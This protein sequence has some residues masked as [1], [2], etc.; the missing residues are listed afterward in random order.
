M[1]RKAATQKSSA[2]KRRKVA[3]SFKPSPK[4]S[5]YPE[6]H[7]FDTERTITAI[8]SN[9]ASWTGTEYDPNTSAM[10][11]LF[12]PQEGD[13]INTRS[14][15]KVFVKKI[16]ISGQIII[17]AQSAASSADAAS[18]VRVIVYMDKQTNIAQSQGEDVIGSGAASDAIHMFQNNNNFGR[19][20]VFK[21]EFFVLE[22]PN[23]NGS[24]TAAS[25]EQQG[26]TTNFKWVIKPNVWVN[27]NQT[28][29]GTVA[30][31]IDNSFHLIANNTVTAL[32]PYLNYKVR[33]VFSP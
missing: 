15:R 5:K 18:L 14:G 12:A 3:G 8:A 32:A 9:A 13:A 2:P 10:L 4:S 29:G 24:A 17:P 23:L 16:T 20:K 11:C 6:N 28:N 7:Y 1:K 22:N 25:I 26:M 19:F 33:T 21:D 27:Y 30:D 31:V